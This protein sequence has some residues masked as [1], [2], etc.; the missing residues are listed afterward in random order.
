MSKQRDFIDDDLATWLGEQHLFFVAT[1]PT[2]LEGHVNCSPKGGDTFRVLG[3]MEVAYMDL[4]GS[5]AETA[6]HL[7][8]NGRIVL[9]FCA[10]EG[11]PNVARLHGR[12]EVIIEGDPH[13]EE[14]VALFP[15]KPGVR[16]VVRVQVTRV[17]TSCGFA[18]PLMDFKDDRDTLDR[19]ALSKGSEGLAE[20][21]LLKNSRS[22]DGL[23]ALFDEPE[24]MA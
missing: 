14:L 17:S 24:T 23:P 5:G 16:S 18:V 13:F 9:M 21:R 2:S 4:T 22:I 19:F 12:G 15:R 20:Y 3:P 10:F 1:A 8:D 7:R 6:A 11:K